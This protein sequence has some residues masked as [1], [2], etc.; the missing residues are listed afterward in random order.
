MDFPTPHREFSTGRSEPSEASPALESPEPIVPSK[1]RRNSAVGTSTTGRR[2]ATGRVQKRVAGTGTFGNRAASVAAGGGGGET[3]GAAGGGGGFGGAVPR[4]I[5]LEPIT[6]DMTEEEKRL[7]RERNEQAEAA[8]NDDRRRNNQSAKR[9]RLKKEMYMVE[10]DMAIKSYKRNVME[11]KQAYES[12]KAVLLR[13]S[14]FSEA[15]MGAGFKEPELWKRPMFMAEQENDIADHRSKLERAAQQADLPKLGLDFADKVYELVGRTVPLAD[16]DSAV[17]ALAEHHQKIEDC[18][19]KQ[20]QLLLQL[21][22]FERKMEETKAKMLDQQRRKQE[23]DMAAEKYKNI[24][25]DDDVED[26]ARLAAAQTQGQAKF[27]PEGMELDRQAEQQGGVDPSMFP[28]SNIAT[29]PVQVGKEQQQQPQ[30]QQTPDNSRPASKGK[31]VDTGDLKPPPTISVAAP[32]PEPVPAT[33]EEDVDNKAF[34]NEIEEFVQAGGMED[35]T[36]IKPDL[37]DDP[38]FS[39]LP[40]SGVDSGPQAFASDDLFSA[41]PGGFPFF[42]HQA[43]DV[44]G[45]SKQQLSSPVPGSGANSAMGA[46]LGTGPSP[47]LDPSATPAFGTPSSSITWPAVGVDSHMRHNTPVSPPI[48]Q[49]IFLGNGANNVS[50][51]TAVQ[52]IQNPQL[53]W[54]MQ[55][56]PIHPQFQHHAQASGRQQQVGS[57]TNPMWNPQ[58]QTM[59]QMFE[60]GFMDMDAESG[61]DSLDMGI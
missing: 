2:V 16:K 6:E 41:P 59:A 36:F 49:G 38:I 22:E 33:R 27:V 60:E 14:L 15:E 46:S 30:Q 24:G 7:A 34:L 57:A 5:E 1:R 21:H 17:K 40:G 47:M 19:R 11:Y 54:P 48:T 31:E 37:F 61:E 58:A 56:H 44:S 28:W 18:E 12:A 35:P 10:M 26:H 52:Q 9:S 32:P 39:G 13:H 29:L 20:Y 25:L 4:P 3:P 55:A 43:F 45:G 42:Q 51:M 8:Y 50:G 23:L 53:T